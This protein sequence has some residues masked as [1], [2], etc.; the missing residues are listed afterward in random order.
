MP[1]GAN[2]VREMEVAQKAVTLYAEKGPFK[3]RELV[4]YMWGEKQAI[5][6]ARG[7][8][9]AVTKILRLHGWVRLR[10]MREGVISY[11]WFPAAE[12]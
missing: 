3:V 6:G 9:D 12:A 5:V 4:R 2:S 8:A 10:K 1:R 11:R 7:V